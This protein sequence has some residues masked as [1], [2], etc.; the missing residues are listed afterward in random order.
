MDGDRHDRGLLAV[1]V[2]AAIATIAVH[3]AYLPRYWP[4]ALGDG[5]AGIFAG[6]IAF[7]VVFYAIGRLRPNAAELPNM[8]GADLGIAL[9]IVSL[10]L[11]G[12]TAGYG[13]LPEDTPWIYAVFAVGLYAGLA[14]IGW[15]LGQRTRAINRIV[16][17]GS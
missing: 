11:A 10:L 17:E 12:M 4:D 14:L 6:W 5:L 13:F 8:R 15:S 16:A 7:T 9:A 2:V 1:L 3:G